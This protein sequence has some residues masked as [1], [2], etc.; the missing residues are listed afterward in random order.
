MVEASLWRSSAGQ[1]STSPRSWVRPP[2]AV[3][4][5]RVCPEDSRSLWVQTTQLWCFEPAYH[6]PEC[7]ITASPLSLLLVWRMT[8]RDTW[9]SLL[10]VH[11]ASVSP[12]VKQK[13]T[14]VCWCEVWW[15]WWTS[16]IH[17]GRS[18]RQSC[19]LGLPKDDHQTCALGKTTSTQPQAVP[20]AKLGF[21]WAERR[22]NL[23]T[24]RW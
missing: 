1:N 15:H 14:P 13:N 19:S 8:H 16:V 3:G 2:L 24:E 22:R 17:S 23:P 6:K 7:S 20:E 18:A 9:S 5:L 4:L 10:Q 12:A 21:G 11:H